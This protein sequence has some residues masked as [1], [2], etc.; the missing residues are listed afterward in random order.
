MQVA[1]IDPGI[2]GALALLTVEQ[3]RIT[4]C[5][6]HATPTTP[7][8]VNGRPRRLYDLPAIYELLSTIPKDAALVL[9]ERQGA[10]P[11]QGTVSTCTTCFGFGVWRMGLVA[12]GLSHRLVEPR[13]WRKVLSLPTALTGDV[14]KRAVRELCMQRLP[15]AGS[16]PLDVCDAIGIALA[17][18]HSV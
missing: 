13:A 15:D 3:G 11:D 17:A 10:R 1:G 6:I 8:K 7:T 4:L 2:R 14:R 18:A 12:C 5:S 9:V 16:L